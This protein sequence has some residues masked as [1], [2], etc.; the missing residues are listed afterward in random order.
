M[1]VTPLFS[2]LNKW[3]DQASAVDQALYML[4]QH[5]TCTSIA[6]TNIA[7]TDQMVHHAVSDIRL[8]LSAGTYLF[9]T[10]LSLPSPSPGHGLGAAQ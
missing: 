8:L 2:L 10:P 7:D 3:Y 9:L 1:A 4:D 6:Y 5:S